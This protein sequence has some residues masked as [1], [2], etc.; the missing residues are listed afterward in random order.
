MRIE[1]ETKVVVRAENGEEV[2]VNDLV[3][4]KTKEKRVLVGFY[5]GINERGAMV[6]TFDGIEMRIMPNSIAEIKKTDGFKLV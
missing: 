4:I 1:K 2:K 3:I 6:F 5:E